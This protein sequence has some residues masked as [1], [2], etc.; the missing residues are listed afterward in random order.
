MVTFLLFGLPIVAPE[1]A[2]SPLEGLDV[3]LTFFGIFAPI[4]VMILTQGAIVGEKESGTAA[5]ILSK[6][7]SR[8]AFILAKLIGNGFAFLIIMV[9][10]QGAI[11]FIQV[12]I[13]GAILSP[14]NFIAAMGVNYLH[15]LFYLSL[16]LMLGT[17]FS[18]R[19][20]VIG[21]PIAILIGQSLV[22]SII[23]AI[24]PFLV[25]MLPKN[26][27]AIANLVSIGEPLPPE[28]PV[29]VIGLSILS[30]LNITIAIW[31]LKREEF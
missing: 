10:G 24:S 31:R 23:E 28:W 19:G 2:V 27:P 15:L 5:W 13:A 22:E 11:A 16:S 25:L 18:T 26:L 20:A 4:G 30:I 9:I 17:M 7:V 6:P 12:A 3:F 21:I 14:M 29:P 1:E 8:S